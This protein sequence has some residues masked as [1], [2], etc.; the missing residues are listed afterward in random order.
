MPTAAPAPVTF[1]PMPDNWAY[2][3][4]SNERSTDSSLWLYVIVDV[5]ARNVSILTRRN[6]EGYDSIPGDHRSWP[7]LPAPRGRTASFDF[8]AVP[9]RMGFVFRL[10]DRDQI[11][12]FLR[13]VATP[14]AQEMLDNLIPVPDTEEWDWTAAA[15]QAAD[16]LRFICD[17]PH[18]VPVA[19]EAGRS[20]AEQRA[21]HR[22]DRSYVDAARLFEVRPDLVDKK[23]ASMS[24]EE[25][26]DR[27][28]TL[29]RFLIHW[30]SN[31][32]HESIH[33][34]LGFT[35]TSDGDWPYIRL[36]GL[37]AFMYG[38]RQRVAG[39]LTVQNADN[40]YARAGIKASADVT[41]AELA[42][43]ARLHTSGALS[44]GLKLI[45][46]EALLRTQRDA[47]RRRI[48][49]QE[50]PAVAAAYAAAEDAF[51]AARARRAALVERILSWGDPADTDT[52]VAKM[53]GMSHTAVGNKRTELDNVDE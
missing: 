38:H 23:W 37:R 42:A 17:Y 46:A 4:N 32:D 5:A 12:T 14:L 45:G 48:R 10:R 34:Q 26:N 47:D 6:D 8:L 11:N 21:A 43:L 16:E 41:E 50:A 30:R 20:V 39:N 22:S 13:D 18:G 15:V 36:V 31:L 3:G 24:N 9:E 19:N 1:T 53:T 35:R 7:K 25:L 33:E 49:E 51:K 27:A 40:W 29:S 28:E 2:P 52:A 44:Q